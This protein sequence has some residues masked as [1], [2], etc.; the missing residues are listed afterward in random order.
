MKLT[1][2]FL[3]LTALSYGQLIINE[4]QSSNNTTLDAND[5]GNYDWIEIYNLT[6]DSL[7]LMNY[8]LSD[9]ADNPTKWQFPKFK[10]AANSYLVI[11]ASGLNTR[12]NNELHTNFK[13]NKNGENLILADLSARLIQQIVIPS[14]PN[15]YSY[16]A[17]PNLSNQF[18]IVVNPTPNSINL[19]SPPPIIECNLS[20][21]FYA[22]KQILE[23]SPNV[24]DLD[25]HYTLNGDNPTIFSP[26][27]SS[28]LIFNNLDNNPIY[29]K[30]PTTPLEN[31]SHLNSFIWKEPKA[32]EKM[33]IIRYAGFLNNEK[34]GSTHTKTIYIDSFFRTRYSFSVLSLITDSLNLFDY[35]NG[36]FIPGK[37]YD[38][39][40]Y[41]F[42]PPG[43]Y[44]H[45]D[46]SWERNVSAQFF[47]EQGKLEWETECG[48]KMHGNGSVSF[49]QKSFQLYFR[50]KYGNKN[51]NYDLFEGSNINEYKRILFR[52]S[53]NDFLQTHFRDAMLHSLLDEF[54][55]EKQ[56]YRSSIV[57]INGEYWGIYNIREKLDKHHFSA[58]AGVHED[59]I[60]IITNCGFDYEGSNLEFLDLQKYLTNHSLKDDANYNYI[61]NKVDI[62]NVI[63]Y[64]IAEIYTANY[65]WPYSNM[66]LWKPRGENTKWRYVIYDLD[67]SFNQDNSS[68]YW[69]KSMN[70][71]TDTNL[72]SYSECSSRLFRKLLQNQH[73]RDNFIERFAYHLNNSLNK[74]IVLNRIEEFESK[75]RDEIEEHI[76]R[77]G[78]PSDKDNW[79]FQ[80]NALKVF[81]RERPCLLLDHL[82]DYFDKKYIDFQCKNF[83]D[84]FSFDNIFI[85]P[86]PLNSNLLTVRNIYQNIRIGH[87]SIIDM[88]GKN[89]IK[90]EL[91]KYPLRIDVSNLANG[92]YILKITHPDGEDASRFILARD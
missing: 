64:F 12:I 29:S 22:K 90:G 47:D 75:Y 43:N 14:I 71:A 10:L 34:V 52:N 62:P 86:N 60:D 4:V 63:D 70:H 44:S 49:P 91:D 5:G 68:G 56:Q 8:F 67:F 87:Y 69:V 92:I 45:R 15:D 1:I 80:V 7:D 57:F 81:A 16:A 6:D 50:K 78:Y 59:S 58:I 42:W 30:I 32:V 13:L 77:W 74:D 83:G 65:D 24:K 48:I 66:R 25:I 27:Y 89:C 26:I 72:F 73:F 84:S 28:P 23:L 9:K 53:G 31:K 61:K 38:D 33:N 51:L 41:S 88:Y 35:K 82:L 2:I 40:G 19:K 46:S 18:T 37:T 21:G 11:F 17:I 79:Y 54:N 20:S 55:I 85:T 76:K 39:M 36:I 3:F